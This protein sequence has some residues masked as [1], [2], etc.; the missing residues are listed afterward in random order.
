MRS[1]ERRVLVTCPEG[2][3]W[4]VKVLDDSPPLPQMVVCPLCRQ[5]HEVLLPMIVKVEALLAT[6]R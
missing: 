5:S 3:E 4:W 2:H 1:S 6:E